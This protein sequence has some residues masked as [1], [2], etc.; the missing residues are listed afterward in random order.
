M[1]LILA[2]VLITI[3]EQSSIIRVA[4]DSFAFIIKLYN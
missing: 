1:P 2:T 3:S 4:T